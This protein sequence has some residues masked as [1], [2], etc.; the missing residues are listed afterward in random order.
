MLIM[1][2]M[3][4]VNADCIFGNISFAEASILFHAVSAA[5]LTLNITHSTRR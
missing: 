5:D 3:K 1:A 2:F 4:D